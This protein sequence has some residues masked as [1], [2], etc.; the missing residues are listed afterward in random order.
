[1]KNPALALR[2]S[3]GHLRRVQV[4]DLPVVADLV[5]Y[6]GSAVNESSPII[7]MKCCDCQI[8][9]QLNLHFSWLDVYVWR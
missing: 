4:H 9:E 7:E 8:A 2:V 1:M 6:D 3:H 5:Q